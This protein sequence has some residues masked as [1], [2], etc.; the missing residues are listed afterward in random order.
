[1]SQKKY[2]DYLSKSNN[3]PGQNKT[4][5]PLINQQGC[6]EGDDGWDEYTEA[7]NV[8]SPH[9]LSQNPSWDLTNDVAIEERAQDLTL[10]FGTPLKV[11]TRPHLIVKLLL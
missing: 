2:Y 6:K 3:G 1:M 9:N 5:S 7:K 4:P 11:P 8:L 10:L